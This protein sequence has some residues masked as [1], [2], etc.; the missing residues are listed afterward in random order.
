MDR[1]PHLHLAH[2]GRTDF[3]G[4]DGALWNI[5]SHENVSLS[6][7]TED[8]TFRLDQAIIYGSFMTEG[9]IIV[10]T[11]ASKL[12]RASVFAKN[13]DQRHALTP[14]STQMACSRASTSPMKPATLPSRM[15]CDDVVAIASGQK[16]RVILSAWIVELSTS[17]IFDSIDG[18]TNRIDIAIQLRSNEESLQSFPHGL[19]GQSWDGD[20]QAIDGALD[21]YP[22][23]GEFRTTAMGEGAIEGVAGDYRLS[24]PFQT[25]FKFSRFGRRRAPPRNT[26]GLNAPRAKSLS[27]AGGT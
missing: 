3:R 8:A 6:M 23:T 18:P 10:R 16:L 1:D 15:R 5:L 20:K 24:S 9:H 12:F 2:G 21:V 14:S 17:T 26:I 11:N 25:E 13:V 4:E 7:K 19:I 27:S 22:T